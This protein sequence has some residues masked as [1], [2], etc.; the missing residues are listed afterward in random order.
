MSASFSLEQNEATNLQGSRKRKLQNEEG[1][2]EPMV[3]FLAQPL[4]CSGPDPVLGTGGV[5]N[6][7]MVQPCP[8]GSH[9]LAGEQTR[10]WPIII[11]RDP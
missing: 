11:I 7:A 3:V 8:Q 1:S 6:T 2:L 4:T 5:E 10:Q 9:R